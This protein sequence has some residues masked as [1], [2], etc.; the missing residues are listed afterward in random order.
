MMYFP[1]FPA[2]RLAG[3][4]PL[5]IIPESVLVLTFSSCA[6]LANEK[7]LSVFNECSLPNPQARRIAGDRCGIGWFGL[8]GLVSDG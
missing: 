4:H 8:V 6:A 7:T 5:L 2:V 3:M 1:L